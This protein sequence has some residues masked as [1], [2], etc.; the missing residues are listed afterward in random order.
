MSK[1]F[2]IQFQEKVRKMTKDLEEQTARDAFN[3]M[4]TKEGKDKVLNPDGCIPILKVKFWSPTSFSEKVRSRVL[5]H[6]SKVMKSDTFVRKFKEIRDMTIS[7]YIETCSKLDE[8]FENDTEHLGR[9]PNTSTEK[10]PD[11]EIHD[12][13]FAVPI[14]LAGFISLPISIVLAGAYLVVNLSISGTKKSIINDSYEECVTLVCD[15]LKQKSCHTLSEIIDK[16]MLD[17]FPRRIAAYEERTRQLQNMYDIVCAE[18]GM[19]L[20]IAEKIN[21]MKNTVNIMNQNL[22][23]KKM[24]AQKN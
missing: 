9:N 7:F 2:E 20:K 17:L 18:H 5:L 14:V 19:L 24:I 22:K 11:S 3:Y 4:R 21:F 12:A 13:L 8:E 10:S 1:C 15:T 23:V 6:V 16:V